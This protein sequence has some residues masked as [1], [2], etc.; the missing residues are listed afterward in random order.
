[1]IEGTGELLGEPA[2][3]RH[4][5][6]KLHRAFPMCDKR[7]WPAW[8]LDCMQPASVPPLMHADLHG[9]R[10]AGAQAVGQQV[11]GSGVGSDG[12]KARI[13]AVKWRH[14]Q[15]RGR[16]DRTADGTLSCR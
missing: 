16:R 10:V 1:M 9:A 4:R 6:P 8:A 13:G 15:L 2:A 11:V 5:R 7:T 3:I 14:S 12:G